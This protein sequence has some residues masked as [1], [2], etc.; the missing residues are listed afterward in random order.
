MVSLRVQKS[1][2]YYERAHF[3]HGNELYG[4]NQ[5]VTIVLA[6]TVDDIRRVGKRCRSGQVTC[7]VAFIG[8]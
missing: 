6:A 2:K 8:I 1:I 4:A 7:K 3:R 5:H